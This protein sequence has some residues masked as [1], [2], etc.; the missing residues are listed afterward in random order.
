MV[1]V[2]AWL[3]GGPADGRI[4]AVKRRADGELPEVVRLPQTGV[5][6]GVSDVPAAVVEHS[7]VR[8]EDIECQVSYQYHQLPAR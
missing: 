6:V 5:Y 4:M 8:V 1:A 7:Y 3:M 2:E